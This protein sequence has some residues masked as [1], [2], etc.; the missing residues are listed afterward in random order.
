MKKI[1]N[2][3]RNLVI[4]LFF[5]LLFIKS[6]QTDFLFIIWVLAG[7]FITCFAD[8]FLVKILKKKYTFPKSAI[9]SG[10]IVAGILDYHQ[11]W[12]VLVIFSLVSIFSKYLIKYNSRH[13]F[14]PANFSLAIAT[15]CGLPLTWNIEANIYIIIACGIYIAYTLKKMP[16][17][18]GFLV[19]FA[20]L[21]AVQGVNPLLLISWLF[22]FVMLIEPKTSGYGILR[23]FIFGSISGVSAFLIF[24][25]FPQYD[26]FIISLFIANLF[27]ILLEKIKPE[28]LSHILK[29]FYKSKVIGLIVKLFSGPDN[30]A[31]THGKSGILQIQKWRVLLR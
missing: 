30:L 29:F 9:I 5:I 13:I 28:S 22:I 26:L 27:N 4:A 23:G 7:A 6:F 11:T 16:H 17:L 19:F 31:K 25:F 10:V 15:L 8:M 18:C 24:K 1:L 3:K 21:F 14:N 12:F 2:D 20:G